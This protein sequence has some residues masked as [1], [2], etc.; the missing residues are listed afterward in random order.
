MRSRFSA[1]ALDLSGYVLATWHPD[2]RPASLESDP[3]LRW[4]R[5]EVLE[6]TGG[7]VFDAEGTVAFRAHYREGGEPGV[8][9]ELSRFVRH[10]GRW[11]YHS[12][13]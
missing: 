11:V 3:G 2:T 4:V 8:M 9:N 1:F 12:P 10:N 13:V 6:S 5:L 7:G